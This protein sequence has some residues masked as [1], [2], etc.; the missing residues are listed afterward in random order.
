MPWSPVYLVHFAKDTEISEINGSSGSTCD[1]PC[2][3]PPAQPERAKRR[4]K[5]TAEQIIGLFIF[6]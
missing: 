3:D 2:G 1:S 4:P 6:E 5:T